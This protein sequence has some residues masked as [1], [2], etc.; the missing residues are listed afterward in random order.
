MKTYIYSL[1]IILAFSFSTKAQERNNH[2][3]KIK[4][5]KIAYLTEQLNL[6]S[7]EAEKFWPAYNAHQENLNTFRKTISK[8]LMEKMKNYSSLKES[9]AKALINTKL[10][11]DKKSFLEKE[12]FIKKLSKI[13]TYKKIL[14]L[15]I[16]EREFGRKLMR[17]YRR[18]KSKD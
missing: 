14:K 17:K 16:A 6:T 11:I 2:R 3:E 8:N 15:Q 18:K 4:T 5:L 9:E 1:I 10:D 7:T 13:L 12:A